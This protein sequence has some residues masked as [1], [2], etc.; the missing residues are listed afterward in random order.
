VI[1]EG[2]DSQLGVTPVDHL[3]F[4]VRT[5]RRYLWAAQCDHAGALFYCPKG[6]IPMP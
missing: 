3:D 2:I 4:I 5:I 6:G 1:A